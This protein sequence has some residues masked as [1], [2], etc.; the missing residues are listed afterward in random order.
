[1]TVQITKRV[2]IGMH[3][4]VS[5]HKFKVDDENAFVRFW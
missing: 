3:S 4:F 5:E 1:M 2:K